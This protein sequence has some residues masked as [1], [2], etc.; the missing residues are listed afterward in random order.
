MVVQ[1]LLDRKTEAVS[2]VFFSYRERETQTSKHVL[3][4]ILRQL[5]FAKKTSSDSVE[6][7]YRKHY[8]NN[9]RPDPKELEQ[10]L[11]ATLADMESA[12]LVLDALDECDLTVAKSIVRT[13]LRTI[14]QRGKLRLLVTSR[15]IPD[16][17][18]LFPHDQRLKIEALPEDL[19]M[20]ASRRANEFN[21]SLMSDKELMKTVV[22]EVVQVADGM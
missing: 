10:A 1:D 17:E 19:R 16:C 15:E 4:A 6:A 3:A 18:A 9:T 21:D 2:Y 11:V 22:D 14:V 7:M 8:G 5:L 20:Y 12:H 13:L